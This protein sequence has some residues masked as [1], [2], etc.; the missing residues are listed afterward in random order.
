MQIVEKLRAHSH[1]EQEAG[2]NIIDDDLRVVRVEGHRGQQDVDAQRLQALQVYQ[3]EPDLFR[4]KKIPV[5]K[6]RWSAR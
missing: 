1:Q 6:G 4:I 5:M 2:D 3:E